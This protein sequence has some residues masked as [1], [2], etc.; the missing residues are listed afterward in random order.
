[1]INI[2]VRTE[3][4]YNIIII[5]LIVMD[6]LVVN[7]EN[8]DVLVFYRYLSGLRTSSLKPVQFWTKLDIWSP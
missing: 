3:N 7:V 5:I 2:Y 8:K 4:K 6:N 1:M